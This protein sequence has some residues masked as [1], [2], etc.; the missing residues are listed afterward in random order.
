MKSIEARNLTQTMA[1]ATSR[2]HFMKIAG[3]GALAAVAATRVPRVAGAQPNAFVEP[4]VYASGY[5]SMPADELVWR[6]VADVAAPVGQGASL[7]RALGFAMATV[8][9]LQILDDSAGTERYVQVGESAFVRE[10]ALERRESLY[11]NSVP[12]LRVGLVPP[13]DASYTAGGEFIY[14]STESFAAPP[15]ERLIRL[16]GATLGQGERAELPDTGTQTLVIVTAGRVGLL[17]HGGGDPI[18]VNAGGAIAFATGMSLA[19]VL[20]GKNRFLA[21]QIL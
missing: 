19:G 21:A 2:R 10:A 12:Y 8:G 13:E 14:A 4:S 7:E 6:L 18:G 17:T 20:S 9:P 5:S 1:N 3:A 11:Q 15:G 16:V